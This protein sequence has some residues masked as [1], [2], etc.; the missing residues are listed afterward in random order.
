MTPIHT[1]R[2]R[3]ITIVLAF[4]ALGLLWLPAVAHAWSN[5][6]DYGNGFGTHDWVLYEANRLAASRGCHWLVWSTAQPV[7]DDPD[8]KLHDTWYHC[9]DIWGSTY[10]DAPG[11]AADLYATVVS[12]LRD[13]DRAKASRRFGLL[14]H[15]FADICNPTHT[16]GSDAEDGMHSAYERAVQTRTD[17][18]GEHRTWITFDGIQVRSSARSATV[19]AARWSHQ[20]YGSL[21]RGYT[22]DGYSSAVDTTTKRC[23]NRA[24]ND[25]ADLIVSARKASR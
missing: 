20:Y 4:A 18:K 6:G 9:Y 24:V 7:T 19:A 25:L 10:G 21:V 8:T 11:K 12:A 15:Y 3:R 13:G 17:A 1:R 23:L 16:D 2:G 14:A 5:G 22:A